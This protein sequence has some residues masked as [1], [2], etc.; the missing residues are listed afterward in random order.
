MGEVG[1]EVGGEQAEV[2]PLWEV[3]L[4]LAS[5]STSTLAS[6]QLL[7]FASLFSTV[8]LVLPLALELLP[9]ISFEL[10]SRSDGLQP[11]D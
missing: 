9:T 10:T 11:A 6:R 5:Q 4:S 3:S 7:L 1:E 8:H 2:R